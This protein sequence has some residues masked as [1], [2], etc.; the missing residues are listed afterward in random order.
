MIILAA[1]LLQTATPQPSNDEQIADAH[2]AWVACLTDAATGYA[3]TAEPA[4]TAVTAAFGHC[5]TEER[6]TRQLYL[7]TLPGDYADR[8]IAMNRASAHDRLVSLI[9]DARL[10]KPAH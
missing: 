9:L 10:P 2:R 5:F 3:N 4:E 7:R 6:R 8:T 1:M